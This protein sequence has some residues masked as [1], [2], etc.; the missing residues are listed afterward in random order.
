MPGIQIPPSK[1]TFMADFSFLVE[2]YG[3]LAK[4][5][6][7]GPDEPKAALSQPVTELLTCT[8]KDA[9]RFKTRLHR[10]VR[11]DGGNTDA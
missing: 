9:F 6:L 10:E 4:N 5:P 11:E 1:V 2:R 3:A 7:N 8:A